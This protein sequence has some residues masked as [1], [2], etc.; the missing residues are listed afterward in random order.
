[1][2]EDNFAEQLKWLQ[3]IEG[4]K[5]RYIGFRYATTASVGIRERHN[6]QYNFG[7]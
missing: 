5:S 6:G 3:C 1:M 4:E 7:N 2:I